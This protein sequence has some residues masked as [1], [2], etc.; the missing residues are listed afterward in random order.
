MPPDAHNI[1]QHF[2]VTFV[3]ARAS[4]RRLH[5]V[6]VLFLR[7]GT[8]D[9][10]MASPLSARATNYRVSVGNRALYANCAW[11]SLGI[12]AMLHEDAS[13]SA[14]HSLDG[15]VIAYDVQEG[16][17]VCNPTACVHFAVPFRHWYDDLV[18]T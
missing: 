13:I 6:H 2:G 4:L 5:D 14:R 18:E 15:E 12:P 9:I 3:A 7:P 17:L 10:L 1:A 16:K 11:D 8:D